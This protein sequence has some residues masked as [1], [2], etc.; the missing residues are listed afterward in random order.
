MDGERY[1]IVSSSGLSRF[2]IKNVSA[3]DHGFYVCDATMNLKQPN[4]AVFYLQVPC[5]GKFN[6]NILNCFMEE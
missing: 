6:L 3:A 4:K 1:S 2:I 5:V